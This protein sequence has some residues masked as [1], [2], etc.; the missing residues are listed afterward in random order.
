MQIPQK[1]TFCAHLL[2]TGWTQ[3]RC[4]QSCPTGALTMRH[5]EDGEMQAIVA[6]EKLETYPQHQSDPHVYYR[7]L[8]R[9]TRCFIGGSLAVDIGGKNECA[10]A[11]KVSLVDGAG[12]I[13]GETV[14]DNYGDFKFDKLEANSGRYSLQID[15]AGRDKK[16]VEVNLVKSLYVGTILL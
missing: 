9:F 3:T 4:V 8:Y 11:A 14:S 2:D 12:K 15:Y 16:V 6:S 10:E 5:V 13:V 1:C 7:N